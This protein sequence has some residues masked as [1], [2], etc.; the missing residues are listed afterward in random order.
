[1]KAR[2]AYESLR[3]PVSKAW[4]FL[5]CWIGSPALAVGIA[6]E[7]GVTDWRAR[8]WLVLGGFALG[9]VS[10]IGFED[11]VKRDCEGAVEDSILQEVRDDEDFDFKDRVLEVL[12]RAHARRHLR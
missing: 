5:L 2:E 7:F 3:G 12:E 10:L 1:M 11:E 9:F 6:S 8:F 4:L